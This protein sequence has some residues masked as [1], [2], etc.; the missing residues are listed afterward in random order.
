MQFSDEFSR[1][2]SDFVS[3]EFVDLTILLREEKDGLGWDDRTE[4]SAVSIKAGNRLA[5]I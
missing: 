2:L 5:P 3:R 4:K 1:A